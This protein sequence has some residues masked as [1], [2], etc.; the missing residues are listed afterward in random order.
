MAEAGSENDPAA[1]RKARALA[2]KAIGLGDA[3]GRAFGDLGTSYI[4]EKDSDLAPGIAA[5]ERAH[6]LLPAR[7]DYALHL[8]ALYRRTG[9]RAKA[10]PL[11]K[12]LDAA[13]N[14]QVAY[15]ARA[16]I[17]R[18]ESARA[19]ELVHQQKLDEAAAALR[20]LAAE[21]GGDKD[22]EKQ[23]ADYER[24]AATNRQI[25]A[26]NKAIG[27]VNRGRYAAARKSLEQ[28]LAGS[29]DADIARDA[30]KLLAEVKAAET[31]RR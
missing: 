30:R 17:V 4:V 26:Y 9:D 16:I 15:A 27:D 12:R 25:E 23:A 28:L 22:L 2:Q 8:F 19:T 14:A 7:T 3:S 24:L 21:S 5:L 10:G 6:A 1:F 13:R 18:V 31:L 20:G 29:V 11:Y